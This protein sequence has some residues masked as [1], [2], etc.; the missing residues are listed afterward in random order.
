VE[1]ATTSGR[2]GTSKG[3][4]HVGERAKGKDKGKL[5]KSPKTAKVGKRPHEQSAAEKL[6]T[7]RRPL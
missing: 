2:I 5:K 6:E 7:L 4:R 3:V 1:A